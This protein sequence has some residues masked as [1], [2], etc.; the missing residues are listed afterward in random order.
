MEFRVNINLN[1]N[2]DIKLNNFTGVPRTRTTLPGETVEFDREPTHKPIRNIRESLNL[3][4]NSV[5]RSS[6]EEP[7][8][9]SA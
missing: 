9:I 7:Q 8:A 2:K 4:D 3:G 5:P 6:R 1:Q